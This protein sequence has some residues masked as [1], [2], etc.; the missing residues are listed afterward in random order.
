MLP[1]ILGNGCALIIGLLSAYFALKISGTVPA[2]ILSQ[3]T[4]DYL[5]FY[6]A[7]HQAISGHG[8]LAYNWN[9]M[10][11]ETRSIAY[12]FD[13][14]VNLFDPY[15]VYPPIAAA[16]FAPLALLPF[17]ASRALWFCLTVL[18]LVWAAHSLEEELKL[19]QRGS[20]IF[21]FAAFTSYPVF[22]NLYQGQSC[23]WRSSAHGSSGG[24]IC[25]EP[26]ARAS[27]SRLS[28]RRSS[29]S[30]CRCWSRVASGRSFGRSP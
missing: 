8:A 4:S 14:P 12:P 6:A 16:L 1:Y 27:P 26:Q 24:A 29:W 21:R 20:A 19:S 17:D 22:Q 25:R 3:R 9:A 28:N 13:V 15:F 5:N 7:G 30:C 18:A 10:L 2:N 11:K 23:C